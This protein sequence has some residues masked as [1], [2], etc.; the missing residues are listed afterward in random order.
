M[1]S[2]QDSRT[3]RICASGNMQLQAAELIP[4]VSEAV[5]MCEER[6]GSLAYDATFGTDLW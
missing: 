3:T 2:S 1:E 5:K 6:G 4:A